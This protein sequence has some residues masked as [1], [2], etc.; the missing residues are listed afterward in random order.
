MI[1]VIGTTDIVDKGTD[2]VVF[3]TCEQER[4]QVVFQ[5]GTSDAVRALK[6]GEL[7]CKDVADFDNADFDN[8]KEEFMHTKNRSSSFFSSTPVKATVF[9]QHLI[10]DLPPL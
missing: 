6:A 3:R 9:P 2:I 5:M 10:S 4:N 8:V 7:V 1:D